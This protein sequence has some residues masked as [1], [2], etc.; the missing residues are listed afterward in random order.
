MKVIRDAIIGFWVAVAI[1]TGA[2]AW[3]VVGVV[4]DCVTG[5]DIIQVVQGAGGEVL[6]SSSPACPEEGQLFVRMVIIIALVG[7]LLAGMMV[8]R[9]V[10][11]A[12]GDA[13]AAWGGAR[14]AG[15]M[16]GAGGAPPDM[17]DLQAR[18]AQVE[19][20]A[21][22]TRQIDA[23]TAAPLAAPVFPRAVDDTST[24]RVER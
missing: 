11:D 23:T 4:T 3:R 22:R 24:W 7:T 18:L 15:S 10:G 13:A 9:D 5:R 16:R 20:T 19:L 14:A 6:R 12:V 17:I 1:V 2:A 8:A 21:A